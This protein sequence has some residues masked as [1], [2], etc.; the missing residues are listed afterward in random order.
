[1]DRRGR[2]E[3]GPAAPQGPRARL[4]VAGGEEADQV[5]R[6]EQPPHD[7]VQSGRAF[8]ERGR[9]LRRQ[10]AKLGLELQVDPTGAVLEREERLR[11]QRLELLRQLALPLLERPA[12]LEVPEKPLELPD[13]TSQGRVARL[14][15]LPNALEPPLDV[16][17]ISVEALE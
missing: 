3:R 12:F 8:A 11:R 14:R 13:L 16:V 2:L 15:L 10:L 9:L 7:L 6:L 4:L 1:M 17:A 5:E